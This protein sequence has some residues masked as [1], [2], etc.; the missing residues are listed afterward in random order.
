MKQNSSI[1]R[2]FAVLGCLFALPVV[3]GQILSTWTGDGTNDNFSNSDNWD[4][5]VP[6]NGDT[7]I[8]GGTFRVE[9]PSGGLN[10]L[11]AGANI[12]MN[13]SSF[14]DNTNL[15]MNVT[16]TLTFNDDAELFSSDFRLNED[17]TLTWDSNGT[18]APAGPLSDRSN[19]YSSSGTTTNM[20]AGTWELTGN[21]ATDSL[22]LRGGVFNMTGGTMI[23]DNRMR[24]GQDEATTFNLGADASLYSNGLFMNTAGSLFDFEIGASFHIALDGEFTTRLGEGFIAIEGIVQSDMENFTTESVTE[25]FGFGPVDY[26]RITAIPEPR[27]YAAWA[28]LAAL[29]LLWWRTRRLPIKSLSH[30]P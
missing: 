3:H 14:I 6:G 8:V 18:F 20:T 27:T 13:D 10:N 2:L 11:N 5:G 21:G 26:T 28:G 4:E 9:I 7:G 29:A 1:L 22:L 19:F 30:N 24:V 16:G 12:I 17:S 15:A 25:D 23:L